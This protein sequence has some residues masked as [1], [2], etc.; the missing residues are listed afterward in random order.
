MINSISWTTYCAQNK[1]ASSQTNHKFEIDDSL[2]DVMRP[3]PKVMIITF[4]SQS[5]RTLVNQSKLDGMRHRES[6]AGISWLVSD[7]LMITCR[8]QSDTSF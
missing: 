5:Q 3:T 4:I 8:W 7:L 2:I 6:C 1:Q